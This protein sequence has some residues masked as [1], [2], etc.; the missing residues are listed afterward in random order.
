MLSDTDLTIAGQTFTISE[1]LIAALVV[2]G[3]ALLLSAFRRT[4]KVALLRSAA[5]EEI[6]IYL[7]RMADSLDQI[8]N[9]PPERVVISETVRPIESS[10]PP[11]SPGVEPDGSVS[12][13]MFGR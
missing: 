1:I 11:Q 10:V 12:Y 9:R 8:A 4:Q 5:T 13:S 2:L 3:A 7:G 6:A